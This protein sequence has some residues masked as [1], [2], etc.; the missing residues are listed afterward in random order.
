V[1]PSTRRVTYTPYNYYNGPDS[2]T[3]VATD[4]SMDSSPATV[5]I[6]VVNTTTDTTS[7]IV[8]ITEYQNGHT[9]TGMFTELR[10]NGVL[11]NS[12]YSHVDFQ[13]NNGQTYTV[14]ASNFQNYTFDHWKDTGSTNP[15]RSINI[16]RDTAIIA[17]FRLQ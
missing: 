15:V 11:V 8:V 13:V 2:F 5:S 17:V 12:G 7:D 1:D 6:N 9:L 14:T 16:N 3:F 10:Q 4:G